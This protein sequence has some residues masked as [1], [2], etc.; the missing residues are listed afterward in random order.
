MMSRL[1]CNRLQGVDKDKSTRREDR[2]SKRTDYQ[3]HSEQLAA[4]ECA[5]SP[6]K[7]QWQGRHQGKRCG[8]QAKRSARTDLGKPLTIIVGTASGC[9][10]VRECCRRDG[11]K[12][13]TK[14]E[15]VSRG[16]GMILQRRVVFVVCDKMG[17]P[18]FGRV[19]V[20]F[21][22]MGS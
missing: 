6:G 4:T 16:Y 1:P 14:R 15:E 8:S 12:D 22:T 10:N 20:S 7:G 13:T 18:S 5:L 21:E 11:E 17:R 19:I 9:L 3:H 2:R